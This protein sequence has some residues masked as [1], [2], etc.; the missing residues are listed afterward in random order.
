MSVAVIVCIINSTAIVAS[1]TPHSNTE[2][3]LWSSHITS[4]ELSLDGLGNTLR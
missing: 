3:M 1:L 2:Y 4:E